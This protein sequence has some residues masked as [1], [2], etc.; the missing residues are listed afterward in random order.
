V[1]KLALV[2]FLRFSLLIA[3]PPL[4]HIHLSPLPVVCDSTVTFWGLSSHLAFVWLQ[5]QEVNLMV[6]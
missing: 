5:V 6:M 3:I 2:E 4:P 1:D